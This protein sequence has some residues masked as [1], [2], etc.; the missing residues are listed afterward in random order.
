MSED[1]LEV[2][3]GAMGALVLLFAECRELGIPVSEHMPLDTPACQ[4]AAVMHLSL[5]VRRARERRR[6]GEKGP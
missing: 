6:T 5:L 2:D 3:A 4:R 1:G